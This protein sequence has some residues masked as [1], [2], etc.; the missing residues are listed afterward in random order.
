MAEHV[1]D[2]TTLDANEFAAQ[3]G[4]PVDALEELWS[5]WSVVRFEEAEQSRYPTWQLAEGSILNTNTHR[6]LAHASEA[7]ISPPQ[8][9]EWM[10]STGAAREFAAD[11]D[12][13][14][15]RFDAEHGI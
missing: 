12:G 13:V 6:L 3:I 14:I 1:Q 5:E 4:V 2:G 8:L 7:D 11:P 15:A 10:V 9:H